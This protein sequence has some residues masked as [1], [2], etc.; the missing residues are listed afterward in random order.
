VR[1]TAHPDVVIAR[2]SAKQ[3][4]QAHGYFQGLHFSQARNGKASKNSG[5]KQYK[6][7]LQRRAHLGIA[8]G[9]RAVP[10]L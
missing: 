2:P 8:T 7:G 10:G 9:P 6:F 1:L 3:R 4:I 5:K